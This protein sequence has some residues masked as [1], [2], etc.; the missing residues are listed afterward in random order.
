MWYAGKRGE[1]H[2]KVLLEKVMERGLLEDL[3]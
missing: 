3:F 1:I 2:I